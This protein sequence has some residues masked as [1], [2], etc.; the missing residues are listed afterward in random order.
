MLGG[1][2]GV[3]DLRRV[4]FL[5]LGE[6][7]CFGIENRVGTPRRVA[8]G[9]RVCTGGAGNRTRRR[10]A[11]PL[12]TKG[13]F[14]V[15]PCPPLVPRSQSLL[16]G[17]DSRTHVRGVLGEKTTRVWSLT[18]AAPGELFPRTNPYTAK[19]GIVILNLI[20][21]LPFHDVITEKLKLG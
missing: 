6:F 10:R 11:Q 14:I 1:A 9:S 3:S 16:H 17:R 18:D 8:A 19:S 13:F 20:Y 21:R 2:A 4:L 15:K 12:E 7:F 5:T